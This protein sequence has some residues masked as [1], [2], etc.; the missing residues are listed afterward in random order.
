MAEDRIATFMA[1][2]EGK[3]I[4]YLRFELPDM[5]GVSRSKTVPIDKASN[6]VPATGLHAG[7]GGKNTSPEGGA[8]SKN[9]RSR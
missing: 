5:H 3:Q 6:V 4:E 9:L 1:E 8:Q 2:L 7:T